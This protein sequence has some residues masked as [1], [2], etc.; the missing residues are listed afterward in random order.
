[1]EDLTFNNGHIAQEFLSLWTML[2]DSSIRKTVN[3]FYDDD[4][5]VFDWYATFPETQQFFKIVGLILKLRSTAEAKEAHKLEEARQ[6]EAFL[7][8][9]KE[10]S[11]QRLKVSQEHH[12]NLRTCARENLKDLRDVLENFEIGLDRVDANAN[13]EPQKTGRLLS[14][15]KHTVKLDSNLGEH[16]SLCHELGKGSSKDDVDVDKAVLSSRSKPTKRKINIATP[17]SHFADAADG[18]TRWAH[19][20]YG[21]TPT[22]RSRSQPIQA[23]WDKPKSTRNVRPR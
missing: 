6:L 22:S 16:P 14:P 7:R 4:F 12:T 13:P 10:S 21:S 3:A 19:N 2:P 17:P 11:D 15:R 23:P 5:A 9:E 8:K 1:M 20:S 18:S